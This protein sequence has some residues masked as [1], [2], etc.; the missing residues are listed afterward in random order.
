MIVLQ[1]SSEPPLA[2]G[3]DLL[4]TTAN[5][6]VPITNRSE[7]IFLS[8]LGLRTDLLQSTMWYTLAGLYSNRAVAGTESP[9]ASRNDLLSSTL[10]VPAANRLRKLSSQSA[11]SKLLNARR[12]PE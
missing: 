10:S 7:I 12:S 3:G 11:G 6:S 5:L 9:L 1:A 2:P 8:L 4:L